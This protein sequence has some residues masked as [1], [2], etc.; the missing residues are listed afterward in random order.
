MLSPLDNSTA[1]SE[2]LDG[3]AGCLRIRLGGGDDTDVAVPAEN[4]RAR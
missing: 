1:I 2:I 4:R 3:D